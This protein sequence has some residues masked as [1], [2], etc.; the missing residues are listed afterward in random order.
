VTASY[1]IFAGPLISVRMTRLQMQ[2]ARSAQIPRI[3]PRGAQKIN[4]PSSSPENC[5][6]CSRSQ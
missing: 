6:W 1:R 5:S 2:E 4:Q 3:K